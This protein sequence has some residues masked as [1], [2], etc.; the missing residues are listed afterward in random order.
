MVYT[1]NGARAKTPTEL[2]RQELKA[3]TQ[4]RLPKLGN[5]MT[6]KEQSKIEKRAAHDKEEAALSKTNRDK[7]IMNTIANTSI[8][9]MSTLMGGLTEIMM[10]ATGSMASGMAE[11]LGGEKA[12]KKVKRE[13]KQK[14]PEVDE[15]I[16]EMIADVRKDVYAQIGQK[17][18]EIEPFLSDP[19]FDAGPK[20]IDEYDFKLPKLTEELDD[21][22]LAQYTRLMVTEDKN[23][24]EMFEK[25]TTWMNTLPNPRRKLARNS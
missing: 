22:S 19:V 25:L 6:R 23:F 16:R 21:D 15:K 5:L 4:I 9:L 12:G 3:T 18:K 8:I 17:R 2:H 20:T 11:A 14:Q 7:K 13:F 24:A 10:K 1:Q